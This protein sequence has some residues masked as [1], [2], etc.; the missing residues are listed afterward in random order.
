MPPVD[1]GLTESWKDILKAKVFRAAGE[2]A[3]DVDGHILKTPRVKLNC[4]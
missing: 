1:G 4:I 2:S 3:D